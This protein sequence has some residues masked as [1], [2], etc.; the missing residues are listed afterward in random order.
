[1]SAGIECQVAAPSK[2][3]RPAGDRVKT[4]A[5]DAEYLA[6]LLRL[7]QIVV[8]T[9]PSAQAE[10][11]RDVVRAGED[12]RQ[13]FMSNRHQLSKLLLCHG[14]VYDCGEAWTGKHDRWLR[15]HQTSGDTAFTP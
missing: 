11:V 14:H 1:M 13:V 12:T 10:T 7:G 15:D 2:L 8:V 6:K 5:R 9:V 4:D 3:Q